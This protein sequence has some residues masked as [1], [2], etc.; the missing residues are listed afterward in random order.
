MEQNWHNVNGSVTFSVRWDDIVRAILPQ[1]LGGGADPQGVSSAL[2]SLAHQTAIRLSDPAAEH[3]GWRSAVLSRSDYGKVMNQMVALGLI[4]A[5][6]I[7]A[8]ETVWYATPYGIQVGSRL[9]A[10]KKGT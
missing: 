6:R 2:A 4:A 8:R 3:D 10:V 5:E 7:G 1:T 9:A